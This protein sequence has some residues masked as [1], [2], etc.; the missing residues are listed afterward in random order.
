MRR[1]PWVLICRE[2]G[3]KLQIDEY[4]ATTEELYLSQTLD[5]YGGRDPCVVKQM[6]NDLPDW[7]EV[8]NSQTWT[9]QAIFESLPDGLPVYYGGVAKPNKIEGGELIGYDDEVARIKP[10]LLTV[11][12]K[13]IS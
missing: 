9:F 5:Y 13:R 2:T 6:N 3:T 12:C 11:T 8:W 10:Y 4:N 7:T 1:K